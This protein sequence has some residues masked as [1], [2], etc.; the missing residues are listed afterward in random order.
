[1]NISDFRHDLMCAILALS[2]KVKYEDK[3]LHV[4]DSKMLISFI[5]WWFNRYEKNL[6]IEQGVAYAEESKR[7]VGNYP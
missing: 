3:L 1:M 2:K 4:I 6:M 7:D 5:S